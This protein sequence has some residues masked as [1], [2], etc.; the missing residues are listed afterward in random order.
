MVFSQIPNI[1]KGNMLFDFYGNFE[2]SKYKDIDDTRITRFRFNPNVGYFFTD[3]LA[4]AITWWLPT[5]WRHRAACGPATRGWF[6]TFTSSST[7]RT[8]HP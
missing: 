8:G 1:K 7:I 4:V 6:R 2:S 3:K 5:N